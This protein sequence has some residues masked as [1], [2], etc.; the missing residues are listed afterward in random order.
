M[1]GIYSR[2]HK[3]IK[4]IIKM[5]DINQTPE[6]IARDNI[7]KMLGEAGWKVQKKKEINLNS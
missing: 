7:D 1:S 6:E 5:S 2:R 3:G 4:K